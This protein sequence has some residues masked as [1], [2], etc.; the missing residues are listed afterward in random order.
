[1]KRAAIVLLIITALFFGCAIGTVAHNLVAPD[2]VAQTTP[3]V[4]GPCSCVAFGDGQKYG[5]NKHCVCNG[6]NCLVVQA[7]TTSS[8]AVSCVPN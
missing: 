3:S 5:L 2:A 7:T 8:P 6:L 4:A 1:M